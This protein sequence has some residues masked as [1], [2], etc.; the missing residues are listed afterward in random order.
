MINRWKQR[1]LESTT[2]A[3]EI[4]LNSARYT[5]QLFGSPRR[6]HAPAISSK[7]VYFNLPIIILHRPSSILEHFLINNR[8]IALHL[9]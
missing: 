8:T 3:P 7:L 6:V 9:T 5:A 1:P 4:Q 2:I